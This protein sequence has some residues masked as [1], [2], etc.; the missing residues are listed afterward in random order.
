MQY[1]CSTK[2][3]TR[4]WEL[5]TNEADVHVYDVI[6]MQQLFLQ[7]DYTGFR[8][9]LGDAQNAASIMKKQSHVEK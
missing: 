1:T 9:A 4:Y 7:E 2:P 5:G 8:D 3:G 6:L